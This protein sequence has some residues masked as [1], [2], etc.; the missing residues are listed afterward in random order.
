MARCTGRPWP[1][2]T[3]PC[4][5]RKDVWIAASRKRALRCI[6]YVQPGIYTGPYMPCAPYFV[7]VAHAVTTIDA[8]GTLTRPALALS[9]QRVQTPDARPALRANLR[10]LK[11]IA[12]GNPQPSPSPIRCILHP[13]SAVASV[14]AIDSTQRTTP[15]RHDFTH[16]RQHRTGRDTTGRDYPPCAPYL[17]TYGTYAPR[18]R[19]DGASQYIMSNRFVCP[20]HPIPS[21]HIHPTSSTPPFPPPPPRNSNPS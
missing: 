14:L 8:H 20:T 16:T 17:P 10:P 3:V 18:Q 9:K 11:S 21:H 13:H 12:A 15:A 4:T 2:L 6:L 1:A 19:L 5:C 7:I